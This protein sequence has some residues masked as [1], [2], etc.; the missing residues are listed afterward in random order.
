MV[1]K[2]AEHRNHHDP[3][4]ELRDRTIDNHV[5]STVGALGGC[6]HSASLAKP[7]KYQDHAPKTLD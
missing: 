1:D 3:T 4:A 6:R 5:L 2:V 7:L